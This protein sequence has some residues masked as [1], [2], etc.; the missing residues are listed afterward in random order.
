MSG[1]TPGPVALRETTFGRV[2][3][4]RGAY[5]YD[6]LVDG[7]PIFNLPSPS[8]ALLRV[9]LDAYN[10]GLAAARQAGEEV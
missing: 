2:S 6:V 4:G 1:A 3:T 7:R 9:A 10:A 5:T 8:N